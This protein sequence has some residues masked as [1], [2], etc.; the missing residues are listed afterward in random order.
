MWPSTFTEEDAAFGFKEMEV[1]SHFYSEH[2]YI[3]NDEAS[4]MLKEW[5]LLRSR[6]STHRKSELV[7]VY[8][9]LLKE[10]CT[11]LKNIL[12]MVEIMLTISIFS[13]EP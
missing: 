3:S 11:E 12:V 1:L 6:V 8:G 9:D 2:G 13:N 10:A 5:P 4:G 7:V